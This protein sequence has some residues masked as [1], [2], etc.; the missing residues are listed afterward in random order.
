MSILDENLIPINYSIIDDPTNVRDNM[1]MFNGIEDVRLYEKN[2]K[3]RFM[4]T[5]MSHS[6]NGNNLIVSGIYDYQN[7]KM[8][9][10]KTIESP[11]SCWC[12]K[13]WTPFVKN[14]FDLVVYKWSPMEV[15]SIVDDDSEVNR[16]EKLF[17]YNVKNDIFSKFRGSS[18]FTRIG[19]NLIGLVHFS[20]GEN[21]RRK[22]FHALV[23]ID[24][25]TMKP[26]KYSNNFYFSE[27]PGVEFCTGF[28]IID[29]KYH[30][31]ISVLDGSPM[32]VSVSIDSIPLCNEVFFQ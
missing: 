29:M 5:S 9:N 12:E 10:C 20:E 24:G 25:L 31:W 17:S 32:K 2:D 30:F 22:Y 19:D 26:T 16:L 11:N 18:V 13:N 1:M 14:D 21:L 27:E 15:C 3:I 8:E 7:L 6:N 28:A 4:A 23:L